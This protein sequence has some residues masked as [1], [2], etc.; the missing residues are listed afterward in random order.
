MSMSWSFLSHQTSLLDKV[1]VRIKNKKG[2]KTTKNLLRFE[3]KVF[4]AFFVCFF[5]TEVFF[6]PVKMLKI[7]KSCDFIHTYPIKL[8]ASVFG[9]HFPYCFYISEKCTSS[10]FVTFSF[11]VNIILLKSTLCKTAEL[12]ERNKI[13]TS[14]LHVERQNC[15]YI[16]SKLSRIALHCS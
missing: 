13:G 16:S 9:F 15:V 4:F 11:Y 10:V 6:F 1:E 12:Q 3:E 7:A 2:R 8:L 5:P 14:A